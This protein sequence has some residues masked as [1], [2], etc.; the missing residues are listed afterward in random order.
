[1][2]SGEEE[3]VIREVPINNVDITEEVAEETSKADEVTEE[4]SEEATNMDVVSDG[5]EEEVTTEEI[6]GVTIDT[7]EEVEIEDAQEEAEQ[8]EEKSTS[9][10]VEKVE[11]EIAS[12]NAEEEMVSDDAEEEIVSDSTEEIED[13][14]V[15]EAEEIQKSDEEDDS[16]DEGEE[17]VEE[18]TNVAD[19]IIEEMNGE[20]ANLEASIENDKNE[21]G[22]YN[23]KVSNELK[24]LFE[25]GDKKLIETNLETLRALNVSDS[26]F[27]YAMAGYSYLTDKDLASKLNYLR[28][29]GVS[30]KVVLDAVELH[31][32]DCSL[33]SIK[34]GVN[35]LE[36][37]DLGFDKRYLPI[38]KYGVDNF[39]N[40][41]EELRNNGI[42]PDDSE[43][44]AYLPILTK[45]ADNVASDTEVLKDYGISL[46]RKNGKYELGLYLKKPAD[47]VQSIDDIIESGEEALIN[48]T[49][50]VLALDTD[51]IIQRLMY[52]KKNKVDYK[53]GEV[54][55]DYIYKP[56]LFNR[57]FDNPELESIG[58]REE[59]NTALSKSLNNDL[60]SIFIEVLDKYY[61]DERSYKAVDLSEEERGVF[62]ELK[63]LL[64]KEFDAK[65]INKNTYEMNGVTISRNKFE[66]NLSCLVSAL[67]S[68]GEDL[69]SE[70]RETLIVAALYNSRRPE[71]MI[72]NI[73]QEVERETARL[74][75]MAA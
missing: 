14:V 60:C 62:E 37:S 11:E 73:P 30:E 4:V 56:N 26:T 55:A 23:S 31:Y 33:E 25:N 8:I 38:L 35:A 49:P 52:V 24:A 36:N 1:M 12:D 50:E 44:A 27:Y 2:D 70:A 41:L 18:S 10:E 34:E 68:N 5:S 46:L 16:S 72:M 17:E 48:N 22:L 42:E 29:K 75:G 63:A 61:E 13:E 71:G 43:I 65:L 74:G 40:A 21:Y 6:S 66:R 9:E 59:C 58:S 64:E 3:E 47:L 20:V 69:L 57:E 67:L 32:I 54:Y 15:E 51:A 45:Y 53:E 7:S 19:K 28:G 39:F